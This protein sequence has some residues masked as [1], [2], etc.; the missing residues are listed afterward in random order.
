MVTV[1]H[2]ARVIVSNR[3]PTEQEETVKQQ[4]EG[5][6]QRDALN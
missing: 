6:M 3:R 1:G 2:I 4:S 5:D